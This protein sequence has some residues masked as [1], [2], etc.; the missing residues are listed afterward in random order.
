MAMAMA[1]AMVAVAA[2]AVPRIEVY[3]VLVVSANAAGVGAAVTASHN[4]KYTVKVMEPLGM[5]GGMAAAGGVALMNQGGCGL[6][7]LSRNWSM[8]CGEYYY[9]YPTKMIFPSMNVSEWAFWQLLH[10]RH[11]IDVE[12]GCRVTH[13]H[14][15]SSGSPG[16]LHQVDFLCADDTEP[17]S[18]IASYIIDASY[19]G[20]VMTGAGGIDYA[21]GREGRD[22]FNESLAGVLLHND[23]LE[24]FEKQNLFVDPYFANGTLLPYIDAGPLPPLG[25]GDD[26]VMAYQYFACLSDTPGNMVPYAA[27]QGYNPDDFTLLLRMIEDLVA[28]GKHPTGPPLD[29][30]GGIQCYDEIVEKVTGNRDCLFCCGTGPVD[31]DQPD[32]NHGWPWANY[33]ERQRI[34]QAHRYYLQGLLYFIAND[35]RVPNGTRA[36]ARAFGYCKDEYRDYGNWPPQ[37]YIRISNRLQGEATLTQNN[38]VNPQAKADGVAMGCWEFDQ[39][40]MSRH[41]VPDPTH[42]GKMVVRNE[43]FMRASLFSGVSCDHPDADCSESANW[44]DVP[45]GTMAPKR[46]QASNLLVPVVISTSSVAYASTRIENMFM[47]LGSAAGVA[48]AL[49]LDDGAAANKGACPTTPVQDTNVTAVQNVLSAVYGQSFHGPGQHPATPIPHWYSVGGAGSPEWDGNYTISNATADGRFIYLQAP[50]SGEPTHGERALYSYAD[51]WRLGRM[52]VEIFYVAGQP[53][54]GPIVPLSG[55]TVA[56]ATAPAPVLVA[57]P[58]QPTPKG[59]RAM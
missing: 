10:S 31:A 21:Y 36:S 1:M 26:K 14:R 25:T 49:L 59:V 7:G 8:L 16:C 28:S 32:L 13:V 39:H 47:D 20:D 57:G 46:D 11:S 2:S 17:V 30:F 15:N 38:I 34:A 4:N 19:D 23:T 3:D 44:Y 53:S 45:F 43:G 6:T 58:L 55:W 22:V 50:S 48:V 41:A 37:L 40:T 35:P 42:P 18:V 9:G 54:D 27:P 29:Y 5:I 33:T 56:N 24:S 52:Y 12:T 51:T